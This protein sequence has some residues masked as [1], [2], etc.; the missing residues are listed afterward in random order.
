[1]VRILGKE[2]VYWDMILLGNF[3]VDYIL[4]WV[5][6]RL[7]NVQV[8]TWRLFLGAGFGALY[9]LCCLFSYNNLIDFWLVKILVS[10]VMVTLV[11]FPKPI[12]IWGYCLGFFYGSSFILGGVI[13]GFGFLIY[14]GDL[15]G[16]NNEFWFFLEKHF[17]S[18]FGLAFFFLMLATFIIPKYYRKRSIKE[19][20]FFGLTI[21]LG[22]KKINI[23]GLVDTG[24]SLTEPF[25][26]IPVVV[27]EYEAIKDI[28]P[29][30]FR[31]SMEKN[32][33]EMDI[34]NEMLES[35]WVNR[36]RLIPFK[37]LG[38]ERGFLVGIKPDFLE[39]LIDEKIKKV[40]KIL[41][42]LSRSHL[43]PQRRYKALLH[44]ELMIENTVA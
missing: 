2:I 34:L 20:Y 27:V 33:D 10:L 42:G 39:L 40:E 31:K 7:A 30:F 15:W 23:N 25:S 4:L 5:A 14:K 29:D 13:I 43:D 32:Q 38:K 18:G 35:S 24:N 36:L 11:Y 41:L 22:D 3:F 12:R 8:K 16:I 44:P 28:L 9:A 37:S 17:W 6:G 1:M 21:S 26:G 19:N